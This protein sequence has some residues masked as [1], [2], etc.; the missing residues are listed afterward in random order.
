M[1]AICEPKYNLVRL[2]RPQDLTIT[3]FLKTLTQLDPLPTGLRDSLDADEVADRLADHLGAFVGEGE[4]EALERFCSDVGELAT[5]FSDLASSPKL[6]VA[7]A[8]V[9]HDMCRLFHTDAIELRM[10]CTYIGPGT[11]W[12]PDPYVNWDNILEPSNEARIKDM[13]QIQQFAPFEVG[14][15][16][17]AMYEHNDGPAVV[18]RSPTLSN[19]GDIRVLIRFDS[20]LPW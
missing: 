15:L 5:R 13:N 8:L 18:H 17:G 7:F 1:K 11:L 14:I 19:E 6:R 2:P 10:L 12:V 3:N 9:Q 20:Q 16:K 4:K